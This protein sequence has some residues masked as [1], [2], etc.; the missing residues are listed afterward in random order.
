MKTFAL[1]ALTA[2]AVAAVDGIVPQPFGRERY[3]ET[4]TTSPFVLATKAEPEAPKD[5]AVSPFANLYVVGLGRADG[6]EYV[7]IVRLGEETTPIR[8]WGNTP[9][10]D[11]LTVQQVVWS[12]EFGKS[13]V[14][15][16][17]GSEVGEV[18][19]SE[20]AIKSAVAGTPV[21]Q[22]QQQGGRPPTLPGQPPQGARPGTPAPAPTFNTGRPV[23]PP[24][25]TTIPRPPGSQTPGVGGTTAIPR[26]TGAPQ[27]QGNRGGAPQGASSGESRGRVRVIDN[28]GRR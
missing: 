9:G 13:K 23:N 22:G 14:K 27:F 8:L 28:G 26:P 20:N 10:D 6:K 11:G 18:G 12:N 3:E 25:N 4:R 7:T 19:F 2:S 15:L 17:K 21:P 16:K 1:I 24:Q 5:A